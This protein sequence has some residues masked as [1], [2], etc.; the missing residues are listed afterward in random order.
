MRAIMVM[1][2]TLCRRKL[3]N[4]GAA[5]TVAPNF[6][7][8]GAQAV[9][10][11]NFY[12][13]SLPCMPARRELHTGRYNFLHRSWGPIE[14]FDDSM[15][16]LLK[17]GG[18]YTHICTDHSHYWED[19]G[20]TYLTRYSSW[21]GFR[22]QEGDRWQDVSSAVEVPPLH[23]RYK[24]GESLPHNFANRAEQRGEGAHSCEQTFSAGLRFLEKN[25]ETD[26]WFLTIETFSPHEPFFTPERYKNRYGISGQDTPLF[27][28]PPYAFWQM[29][30]EDRQR[31]NLEYNSSLTM[32]DEQLGRVLDFMDAH[33]LWDDTMLIVN[34]DHGFN[35]GEHDITGKNFGPFYNTVT[36]LPFFLW[37]P[38]LKRGGERSEALAQTI[39]LAPTLLDYF[40]VPIPA[41]MMGVPLTEAVTEG[42]DARPLALYGVFG[43]SVNATDGRYTYFRSSADIDGG[44]CYEYTLMPT[45]MRG[46]FSQGQLARATLQEPLPFT[47]G[48]PVLRTAGHAMINCYKYGHA[49]YDLD[50]DPG[51]ICK[52]SDFELEADFCNRMLTALRSSDA[53]KETIARLGL[54]ENMTAEEVRADREK[55]LADYGQDYGLS[56]P[57]DAQARTALFT[58]RTFLP[59][60]LREETVASFAAWLPA[61]GPAVTQREV[62][63]FL[64]EGGHGIPSVKQVQQLIFAFGDCFIS[65]KELDHYGI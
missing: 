54:H 52:L 60:A 27:D 2:D 21:E 58:L 63:A 6:T 17:A 45:R 48:M 8:L 61:D 51:Q 12:C 42:R 29:E 55:F 7:R 38:K 18:I 50:Q 56:R 26:N 65:E 40:R 5:D 20:A 23:P 47:K 10:F 59:A 64:R 57:L 46:F 41:D 24:K 44:A 34:C 53:T 62:M 11:D 32:C 9:T 25:L 33:S 3:P 19:G 43:D 28:W 49:L 37:N 39:D 14:P 31:V 35:L 4:Y 22:G 15:P 1:Y 30:D 13:G 36:H 16:A